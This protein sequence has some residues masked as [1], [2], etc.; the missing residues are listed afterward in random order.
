MLPE[1]IG[2]RLVRHICNASDLSFAGRLEN[3]LRATLTIGQDEE[4]VLLHAPRKRL[5]I[6]S[7]FCKAAVCLLADAVAGILHSGLQ[8]HSLAMYC[9]VASL[10]LLLVKVSAASRHCQPMYWM[11][12]Q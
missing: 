2:L 7:P 4:E 9:L 8:V 3:M 1:C 6:Q 10:T 5:T 11:M 12:R